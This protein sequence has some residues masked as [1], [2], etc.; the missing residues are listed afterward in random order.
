MPAERPR[1]TGE[2]D[3]NGLPRGLRHDLVNAL[4][5]LL[6]FASFLEADLPDGPQRDFARRIQDA[7]RQ[8]MALAE[9]LPSS[10]RVVAVRVLMV[11][12]AADADPLILELDTYGC[13]VTLVPTPG[14]AVQ[15]LR[16]A[17]G[18]WDVILA[19]QPGPADHAGLAEAAAGLEIIPRTAEITP[20]ALA[21]A[22]RAAGARPGGD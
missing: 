15:V 7:G 17:P 9:R 11:S 13:E 1:G 5:A 4:N 22:L 18:A 14:R 12:G 3:G 19:D 8:A 2:V 21:L 20:A 10:P 16:K 6:G